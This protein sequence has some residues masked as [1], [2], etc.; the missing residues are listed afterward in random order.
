M[1]VLRSTDPIEARGVEQKDYYKLI[2]AILD[3]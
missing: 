2:G 3:S 1:V